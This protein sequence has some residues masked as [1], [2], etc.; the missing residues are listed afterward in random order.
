MDCL[1]DQLQEIEEAYQETSFFDGYFGF[2][3]RYVKTSNECNKF[4]VTGRSNQDTTTARGYH[5]RNEHIIKL[6]YSKGDIV[7]E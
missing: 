5:S 6:Y 7:D 1:L 4:V 3:R 2:E